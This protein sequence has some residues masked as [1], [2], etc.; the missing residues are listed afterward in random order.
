MTAEQLNRL[1]KEN[2]NKYF[3]EREIIE[4][5]KSDDV[6]VDGENIYRYIAEQTEK[7]ES[8]EV[9]R[10]HINEEAK[11][12]YVKHFGEAKETEARQSKSL[13]DVRIDLLDESY[14]LYR[15]TNELKE[16]QKL[17]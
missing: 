9:L 14:R 5:E 7:H 16:S 2:Y 11:E 17:H 12:A 3:K 15:M 8:L 1:A 10:Q 13:E 4:E 6:M